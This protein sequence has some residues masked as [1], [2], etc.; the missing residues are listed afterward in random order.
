MPREV[1]E[2][3]RLIEEGLTLYG[4][5][6]LDN[7]LARWERAL[8]IEPNNAQVNN[9][10]D[11]VRANYDLLTSDLGDTLPKENAPF[12]IADDEPEYQIEI[13][14]GEIKASDALPASPESFDPHDEGWFIDEETKEGGY[15]P[16][17]PGTPVR[18]SQDLTPHAERP[19][20]IE[21]DA[22]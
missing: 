13:Q 20:Q 22:D 10:V 6:D 1:P 19:Y 17:K 4:Q 12:G 18:P 9:Y 3:D 15:R 21:L 11:Y 2:I 8:L 16:P 5:G 7:A 14:P